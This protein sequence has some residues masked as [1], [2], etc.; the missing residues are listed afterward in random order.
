MFD[1]GVGTGEF[2]KGVVGAQRNFWGDFICTCGSWSGARCNIKITG[3]SHRLRYRFPDGTLHWVN[4]LVTAQQMAG[5]NAAGEGD[6]GGPVFFLDAN[7]SNVRAR[8]L[9]ASANLA[10]PAKCTGVDDGRRC[11][12]RFAL[13]DLALHLRSYDLTLLTSR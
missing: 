11:A 9:I 8:G 6:S 13:V 3:T 5:Q 4:Y 10:Y 1:G 12:S 2:T 7:P